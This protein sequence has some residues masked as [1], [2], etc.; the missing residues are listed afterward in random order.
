MESPFIFGYYFSGNP[1][2][3]ASRRICLGKEVLR[4]FEQT[5]V[6]ET[7]FLV[8]II[9]E[10]L[11]EHRNEI[12]TKYKSPELIGKIYSEAKNRYKVE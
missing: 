10:L 8:S 3:I 9:D 12:P 4:L 5:G 2:E 7:E 6:E 1:Y 11:T